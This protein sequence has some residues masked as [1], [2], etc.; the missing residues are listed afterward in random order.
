MISL[1]V[2]DHQPLPSAVPSVVPS[3]AQLVAAM[4]GGN[5]R[6]AAALYERHSAVMYGL[7]LRMVSEPADAEE[8][9]VDSFAQ[10]WR[11]ASSFDT[12]RGSTVGWLTTIVRTRSLDML[13]SVLRRSRMA[14][15]VIALSDEPV[16][17]GESFPAPDAL[18]IDHERGREI[19]WALTTLPAAQRLALELAFFEG[20]THQE[21]AMRLSAPLGTVKTRIR[22][23]MQKLRT[24]LEL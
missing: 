8:V 12:D 21:V 9:V 6:A 7:A 13:R 4:A 19:S 16:G 22:I 23:G 17:M 15:R 18:T 5:E 1:L 3:D 24:Q 2:R 14:A 20:L 10:A 11:T